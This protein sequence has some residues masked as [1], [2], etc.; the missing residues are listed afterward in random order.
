MAVFYSAGKS[1]LAGYQ[2][3]FLL[4]AI[5][6][7][8]IL[9][10]LPFPKFISKVSH[11]EVENILRQYHGK[12]LYRSSLEQFH[13]HPIHIELIMKMQSHHKP[14]LQGCL[15]NVTPLWSAIFQQ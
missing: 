3:Y 6:K 11:P 13:I 5:Q 2:A 14:C 8:R 12:Y 10:T 4:E 1:E 7:Y 9:V 15:G